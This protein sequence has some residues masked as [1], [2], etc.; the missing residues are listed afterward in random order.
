[1]KILSQMRLLTKKSPISLGI[2]PESGIQILT[3][4][5]FG[6]SL[7][8]PSAIVFILRYHFGEIHLI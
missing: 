8:P 7:R 3:G 5:I 4:F 1:M 2:H 6:G